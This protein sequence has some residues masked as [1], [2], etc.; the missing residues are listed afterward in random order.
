MSARAR[1]HMCACL[2]VCSLTKESYT[3]VNMTMVWV[4]IETMMSVMTNML[5]TSMSRGVHHVGS[6]HYLGRGRLM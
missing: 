5:T 2:S 1:V 3:A 4:M 6:V